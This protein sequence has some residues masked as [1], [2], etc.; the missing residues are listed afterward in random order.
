MNRRELKRKKMPRTKFTRTMKN[1]ESRRMRMINKKTMFTR[2]M[3]RSREPLKLRQTRPRVLSQM[4]KMK[5]LK[6]KMVLQM[7]P[8]TKQT[9]FKIMKT[10]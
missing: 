6:W 7:K 1:R 8:T 9:S 3:N 5:T 10:S 2:Q 4:V